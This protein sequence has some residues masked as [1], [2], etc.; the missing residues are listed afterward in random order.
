MIRDNV[1]MVINSMYIAC[2][3]KKKMSMTSFKE[4]WQSTEVIEILAGRML[5]FLQPQV[6][7][8]SFRV[9]LQLFSV[10]QLIK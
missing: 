5:G 2:H 9:V 6:W 4:S 10:L 8:L 7:P 3:V 1:R